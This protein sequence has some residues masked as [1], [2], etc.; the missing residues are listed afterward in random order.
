MPVVF[1][2]PGSLKIGYYLPGTR[3][4]IASDEE[5]IEGRVQPENMLIWGWHIA[6]E[7]RDYLRKQGFEGRIFRPLPDFSLMNDS[8][9]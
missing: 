6:E 5:W 1:E 4:P 8:G 7:I 9:G 3:I 2:K